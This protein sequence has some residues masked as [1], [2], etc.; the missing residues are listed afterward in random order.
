MYISEE[1]I[2]Q[3]IERNGTFST[4]K[5]TKEAL[6][7][8]CLVTLALN[9]ETKT[10]EFSKGEQVFCITGEFGVIGETELQVLYIN[11]EYIILELIWGK[12][13]IRNKEGIVKEIC[14][15]E[16]Q[17][18][19]LTDTEELEKIKWLK[20]DEITKNI[21]IALEFKYKELGKKHKENLLYDSAFD[22][23]LSY[24]KPVKETKTSVHP[25]FSLKIKSIYLDMM[26]DTLREQIIAIR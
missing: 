24:Q 4:I 13:Y 17:Y 14:S 9:P 7:D 3:Q 12:L 26:Q 10:L 16:Q 2:K 22:I 25:L 6:E 8:N 18:K 21:S 23:V 20:V 19:E 11:R 1:L 15:S 5:L